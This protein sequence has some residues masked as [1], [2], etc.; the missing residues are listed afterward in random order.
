MEL[1]SA[2]YLKTLRDL[3]KWVMYKEYLYVLYYEQYTQVAFRY[4]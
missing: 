4:Y 3:G 2:A 1:E